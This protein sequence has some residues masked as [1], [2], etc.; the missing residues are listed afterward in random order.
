MTEMTDTRQEYFEIESSEMFE[1]MFRNF[2]VA[3]LTDKS[4]LLNEYLDACVYQNHN[5]I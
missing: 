1:C 2:R 3:C 4:H 5:W